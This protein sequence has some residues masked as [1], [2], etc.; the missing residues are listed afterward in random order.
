A[1]V[2]DGS[3]LSWMRGGSGTEVWRVTFEASADRTNWYSLGAGTRIPGGWQAT[4]P[5]TGGSLAIRARGFL[6]GA[7][8][9]SS[10]SSFVET[11]AQLRPVIQATSYTPDAFRGSIQALPGQS[12]VVEAST[13]LTQWSV[14]QTNV[15]PL[16]GVILFKDSEAP[17]L[18]GRFYRARVQ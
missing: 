9:Y 18:P 7:G 15:A 10:S 4:N 11:V 8:Y 2:F 1:L 17:S 3:N 12:I 6:A 5:V 16:E 13:N 14:I